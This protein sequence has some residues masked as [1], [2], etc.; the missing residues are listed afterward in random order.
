MGDQGAHEAGI[1]AEQ[2]QAIVSRGSPNYAQVVEE[3]NEAGAQAAQP[4]VQPQVAAQQP[5]NG[6]TDTHNELPSSPTWKVQLQ[7]RRMV[8]LDQV[9]RTISISDW[10]RP[11]GRREPSEYFDLFDG[12]RSWRHR[13]VIRADNWKS[14]AV[15]RGERQV[16][17]SFCGKRNV[18]FEPAKF[19]LRSQQD[20]QS[21]NNFITDLCCLAKYCEFG[22]LRDD[23]IWDT[24][25]AG[26]KD[27]KLSEQLQLDSNLTLEKAITKTRQSETVKKQ[28]TFLQ[29]T[30]SKPTTSLLDRLS[31]GKVKEDMKKEKK[32]PKSKNG[33][34][35]EAQCS[36]CLG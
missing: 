16:W 23:L 8:P 19:N 35:P 7:T 34:T 11:K 32:P 31:K 9:F 21:V 5:I 2:P 25:E 14:K 20:G 24:I 17:S 1:Q 27:K 28:Q 30:K 6:S 10:I 18:I 26:I 12:R 3:P 33:K 15:Q 36:R 22:T 13:N 4:A 29:E